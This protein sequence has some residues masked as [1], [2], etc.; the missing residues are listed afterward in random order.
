MPE[1]FGTYAA[2]QPGYE[3]FKQLGKLEDYVYQS[4]TH[5]G[6]ASYKLSWGLTVLEHTDVP[7]E[8][9]EEIKQAMQAISKVKE[10]LRAHQEEGAEQ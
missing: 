7:V 3:G 9:Q 6:D 1:K 8:V 2:H 10:K 5:L 4:L